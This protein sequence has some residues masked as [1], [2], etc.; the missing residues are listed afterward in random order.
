VSLATKFECAPLLTGCQFLMAPRL[1]KDEKAVWFFCCVMMSDSIH[2]P[3]LVAKT[4]LFPVFR[5]DKLVNDET[6]LR[7]VIGISW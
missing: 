3:L 5:Q 4:D 1:D 6:E 2:R 7:S